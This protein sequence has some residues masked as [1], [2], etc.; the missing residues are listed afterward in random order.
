MSD[1]TWDSEKK[2]N[3]PTVVY[4]DRGSYPDREISR[5]E[6]LRSGSYLA[7]HYVG[8]V[9]ARIEIVEDGSPSGVGYYGRTWP[10][11]ALVRWH[12]Q[13]YGPVRFSIFTPIEDRGGDRIRKVYEMDGTGAMRGRAEHVLNSQGDI[14]SETRMT[15]EGKPI[16]R[17]EY[18]YNENGDLTLTREFGPNGELYDEIRSDRD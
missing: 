5:E 10:D 18:A 16:G 1:H 13:N 7:R 2:L 4:S 3:E 6:A 11:H 9:L 14:L 15:A 8:G 17:L 12:L